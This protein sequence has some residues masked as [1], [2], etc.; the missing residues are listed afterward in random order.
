MYIL[1]PASCLLVGLGAILPIYLAQC[2]NKNTILINNDMEEY[3]LGSNTS[4]FISS[5]ETE[6]FTV[7]NRLLNLK[8]LSEDSKGTTNFIIDGSVNFGFLIDPSMNCHISGK[9]N[10][11]VKFNTGSYAGV[12]FIVGRTNNIGDFV[13]SKKLTIEESVSVD[14]FSLNNAYGIS[15]GEINGGG[16]NIS[17]IFSISANGYGTGLEVLNKVSGI[18]TI[19]GLFNISSSSSSYAMYFW[20]EIYKSV[21]NISGL[22]SINSLNGDSY[23]INFDKISDSTINASS[24]FGLVAN[25]DTYGINFD[26]G[27]TNN[28]FH[29]NPTFYSNKQDSG[30]WVNKTTKNEKWNGVN[31]EQQ[32]T[33]PIGTAD[34]NLEFKK[35]YD[36][37]YEADSHFWLQTIND[38]QTTP[39]NS[40]N[41]FNNELKL[42][43]QKTKNEWIKKIIEKI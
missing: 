24:V 21:L 23:G 5:D 35:I 4:V 28:A 1:I 33:N 25:A 20:S 27:S 18:V 22:F 9:N 3:L 40:K 34:A 15:I 43:L 31:I 10:A 14:V 38:S 26:T 2:N 8:K 41:E 7:G 42:K 17:A 39:V 6:N 32:L 29:T 12:A 13:Y 16:I 19:S 11:S 37:D 30:N 36:T